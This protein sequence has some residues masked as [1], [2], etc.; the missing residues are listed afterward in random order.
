MFLNPIEFEDNERMS[1]NSF[2]D[3]EGALRYHSDDE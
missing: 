2:V 3:D 1:V